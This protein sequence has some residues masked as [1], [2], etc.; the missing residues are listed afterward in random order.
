MFAARYWANR[1]FNVRYWPPI[2]AAP[3]VVISKRYTLKGIDDQKFAL[4]GADDRKFI[5]KGADDQNF[6]LTGA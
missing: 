5:L 2:G 1:F 6:V 3:V 4:E